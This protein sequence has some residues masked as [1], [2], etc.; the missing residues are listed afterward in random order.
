MPAAKLLF[1]LLLFLLIDLLFGG[2]LDIILQL[3][4]YFC[5]LG[6][7]LLRVRGYL[8]HCVAIYFSSYWTCFKRQLLFLPLAITAKVLKSASSMGRTRYTF[9]LG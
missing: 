4:H 5:Q 2:R 6:L 8:Y 9:G 7:L 1:K 3:S